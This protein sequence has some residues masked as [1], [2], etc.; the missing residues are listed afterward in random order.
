MKEGLR[1]C[2]ESRL[3]DGMIDDI[4]DKEL[5]LEN[6]KVLLGEAERRPVRYKPMPGDPVD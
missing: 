1:T 4:E 2:Q 6:L 3:I 5:E